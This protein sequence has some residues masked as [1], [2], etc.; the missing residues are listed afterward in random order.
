[1][2]ETRAGVW[3]ARKQDARRDVEALR[4]LGGGRERSRRSGGIVGSN[5][6]SQRPVEEEGERG[7]PVASEKEVAREKQAARARQALDLAGP[8]RAPRSSR[9]RYVHKCAVRSFKPKEAAEAG[10]CC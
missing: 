1:V 7:V 2:N 10:A 5:R 4:R 8:T 9:R 6:A 3:E